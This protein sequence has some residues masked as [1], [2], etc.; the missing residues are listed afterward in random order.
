MN[1]YRAHAFTL[2]ELMLALLMAAVIGSALLLTLKRSF[3]TIHPAPQSR[4]ASMQ[5]PHDGDTGTLRTILE[6][7]FA[8]AIRWHLEDQVL[9]LHGP[10]SRRHRGEP[11]EVSY[12]FQTMPEGQG[13]LI[14]R[15]TPRLHAERATTDMLLL[16]DIDKLAWIDGDDDSIHRDEGHPESASPQTPYPSLTRLKLRYNLADRSEETLR[17]TRLQ[18][19]P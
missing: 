13:V 3:R 17:L 12:V 6:R 1:R 15:E 7:D 2:I 14:R 4:Q 9:V 16:V 8:Q 11:A 19:Q 18:G 5:A 10:L